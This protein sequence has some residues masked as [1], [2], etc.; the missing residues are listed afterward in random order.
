[1]VAVVVGFGYG[2]LM[3]F[4]LAEV[5]RLAPAE[6][7]AGM[8]AVFQAFTYLGFAAP[9]LLSTLKG[10]ASPGVLLLAVVALGVLTLAV[11]LRN[12]RATAEG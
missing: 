1:V 3:V 12:A 5:Q 6:D 9:Y 8:T 7:L 10:V 4:G 2:I 11:T